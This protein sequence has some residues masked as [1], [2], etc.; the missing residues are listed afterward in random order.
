MAPQQAQQTIL[1]ALVDFYQSLETRRLPELDSLYHPDARLVDPVG[2]HRGLP[3]LRRYFADL[4]KNLRYCRFSIATCELTPAGAVIV[5]HM[6]YAHPALRRGAPLTLPGCS[7]LQFADDRIIFQQ[8]YYDLG[9][10]F[11]EQLP[12][13]GALVRRLKRRLQP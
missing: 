13:V 6:H 1:M 10:M 4:L 7:W 9:A 8:D 3:L 12:L 2:E 11:Y 5:W